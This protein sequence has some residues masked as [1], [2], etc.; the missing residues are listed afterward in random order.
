[1]IFIQMI[2]DSFDFFLSDCFS[3]AGAVQYF[4]FI[5]GFRLL[6]CLKLHFDGF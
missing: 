1:M 5:W 3:S 6:P 2:S 4:I